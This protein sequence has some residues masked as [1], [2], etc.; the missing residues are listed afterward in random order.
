MTKI[1]I[2][3][4]HEQTD[5]LAVGEVSSV[6]LTR[7]YLEQIEAVNPTLNT[8]LHVDPEG[9]LATATA[10]DARRAE[11]EELGPLMGIPIAVKNSFYTTGIPAACGSRI[12]EGRI[13]PY[14]ATVTA[15]LK[16]A[17]PVILDRTNMDELATGSPTETFA[18]GPSHNP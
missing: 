7:T 5:L 15:R 10:I 3:T 4:A 18:F 6:E 16:Q 12:L 1:I 11:S 2:R 13:L 14:D 8:F 17:G 9:V